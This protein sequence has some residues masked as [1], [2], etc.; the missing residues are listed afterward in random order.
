MKNSRKKADIKQ[1]I[2]SHIINN[3]KEYIIM[4]LLFIIGIF[5]GVLFINNL[6]EEQWNNISTYINS[7]IEKLKS[8]ENIDSINLFKNS[9]IQNTI[10][11]VILWFF[12]TTVIRNSSSIWVSCISWILLRIYNIS[13]CRNLRHF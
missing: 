1:L 4:L 5:F 6:Q 12:G 3:K 8:I 9:L 13:V 7:F 11:A 10:L 2:I